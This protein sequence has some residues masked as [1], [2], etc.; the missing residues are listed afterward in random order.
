MSEMASADTP[1]TVHTTHS[2]P[3]FVYPLCMPRFDFRCQKCERVFEAD[4]KFGTKKFPPCPSC[5]NKKTEKLFSPPGIVFKGTGFY[6][7]DA[8]VKPV[9]K[10]PEPAKK[11]EAPKNPG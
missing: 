8:A 7:T 6:K 11:P 2:Q 3:D 4:I 9:E 1:A 5:N 10:K